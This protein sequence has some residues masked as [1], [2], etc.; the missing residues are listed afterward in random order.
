[1]PPL[2]ACMISLFQDQPYVLVRVP[3]SWILN[4][5]FLGVQLVFQCVWSDETL[6]GI[7]KGTSIVS[8]EREIKKHTLSKRWNRYV[9]YLLYSVG[10][11][12]RLGRGEA[13]SLKG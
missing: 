5:I 2:I 10:T 9:Y 3:L 7:C 6:E 8:G 11:F 4:Q 1:M 12:S 13:N